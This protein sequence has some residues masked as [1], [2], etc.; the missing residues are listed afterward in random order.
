MINDYQNQ[1]ATYS[2]V[3]IPWRNIARLQQTI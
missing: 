2:F 3:E 1:M